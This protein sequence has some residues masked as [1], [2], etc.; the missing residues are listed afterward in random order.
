MSCHELNFTLENI[1]RAKETIKVVINDLDRVY[2]V[3]ENDN[4]QVCI[5]MLKNILYQLVQRE[6]TIVYEL[7]NR[8]CMKV[9]DNA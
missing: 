2:R 9:E 5:I 1:R 3:I 4:I 7:Y 8:G 6:I